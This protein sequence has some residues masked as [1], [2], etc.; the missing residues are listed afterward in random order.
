MHP[1][2]RNQ[3]K[4][5]ASKFK[6]YIHSLYNRTNVTFGLLC[7]QDWLEI[8][9]GA[10]PDN[11]QFKRHWKN[12]RPLV[13]RVCRSHL[14]LSDTSIDPIRYIIFV[15]ENLYVTA[16]LV[17]NFYLILSVYSVPR[18]SEKKRPSSKKQAKVV[19]VVPVSLGLR[20][21]ADAP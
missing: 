21:C 5:L 4:S 11:E 20:R 10:A 1:R 13:R 19:G 6:Y 8:H 16:V 14:I 7:Y 2:R 17:I 15:Q 18:P 9:P 12:T 3:S